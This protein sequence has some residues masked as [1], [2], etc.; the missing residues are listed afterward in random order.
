MAGVGHP[1]WN[2]LTGT[3]TG[4]VLLG[5]NIVL[6]IFLMPFTM[7]HLGQS[8][9]GLW[10]LVAS[11][12]AYFQ[13]L[14]LGYGNGLVRQITQAD[15]Q[16]DENGVNEVLSTFLVVYGALGLVALAATA[17]LALTVLPR[18]PNLSPEQIPTAQWVLGLLG[19]RVAIG[20]P[21]GIFGAVTTARQRFVLT[22]C[23]AI[24]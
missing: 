22:G 8:N 19:F 11:M 9:Y 2:L 20:F 15:A 24:A 3:L 5:I 1:A 12:T 10:M 6:G 17:L 14:D 4:Y 16:G 21:M 23:V 18:F 13:L 7:F